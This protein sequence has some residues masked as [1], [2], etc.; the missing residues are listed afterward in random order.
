MTTTPAIAPPETDLPATLAEVDFPPTDLPYDDGEPLESNLHR[1]GMFN[2]I[3]PLLTVPGLNQ[4]FAGGN[5]FIYYSRTQAKNYDFRGPDFFVVLGVDGSKDRKYWATWDEDG[6]YPDVIVEYLSASTAHQDLGAKKDIYEQI[7]RTP[8]YY[9]FDPYDATSLRGWNLVQNSYQPLT[10][11]PQGWLWCDRL[12]LWLG[13][14]SGSIEQLTVPWLR[15]Y[16]PDGSLVL[17]PEELAEQKA[18]AAEQEAEAAE[19]QLEIVQQQAEAAQ[20]QLEIVQQQAET[21]RERAERLAQKL[22]ELGIDPDG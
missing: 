1:I 11:N 2:L 16:Y 10:P 6:R 4:Y 20:Q 8:N 13:T 22:H 21:A 14:W 3:R 19:Q 7:F 17:F 12:N 15:F 9:V 5:M 18:E